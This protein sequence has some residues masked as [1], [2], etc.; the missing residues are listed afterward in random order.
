MVGQADSQ[1]GP[2]TSVGVGKS[3]L[4]KPHKVSKGAQAKGI[5][6]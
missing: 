6:C 4:C 5:L 2:G 1:S 3:T